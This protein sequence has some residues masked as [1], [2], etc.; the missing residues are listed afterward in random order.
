MIETSINNGDCGNN[1][2][3]QWEPGFKE[4]ILNKTGKKNDNSQEHASF[5]GWQCTSKQLSTTYFLFTY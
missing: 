1:D 5:I 3:V 4:S 2:N